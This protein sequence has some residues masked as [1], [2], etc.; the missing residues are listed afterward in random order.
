[1]QGRQGGGEALAVGVLDSVTSGVPVPPNGTL[2]GGVVVRLGLTV[3]VTINV[4]VEVGCSVS[5]TLGG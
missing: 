2:V 3:L 5:V 1:M 4:E